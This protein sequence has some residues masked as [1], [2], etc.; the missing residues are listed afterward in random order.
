MQEGQE[1]QESGR[2][3]FVYE[4]ERRELPAELLREIE[5]QKLQWLN[6]AD[7][8]QHTLERE[9]R[10]IAHGSLLFLKKVLRKAEEESFSLAILPTPRQPKLARLLSL[11]SVE[12][13]LVAFLGSVEPLPLD[14]LYA[15]EEPVFFSALVGEAPPLG[16][17]N[18]VLNEDLECGG[19]LRLFFRALWRV[20]GLRRVLAEVTTAKG[21]TLKTAITGALIFNREAN[22]FAANLLQES[23][24]NDGQLR[25]LLI[26]PLSVLSYLHHLI[27][28]IYAR[29][30]ESSLPGSVG[31][32]KSES[33]TIR[34]DPPLQ[35]SV[36]GVE[37]GETPMTFRVHPKAIR[38]CA[39]ERFWERNRPTQSEK[40][41]L[42][43][44][45]LPK[46]QEAKEVIRK[47]LPLL[48]HASEE[49]YKELFTT[50][51]ADGRLSST[52]VILMI[53]STL[54]ATVG[55]FLN[56]AS[57]VIGAMLLAPLMQPIVTFA[58][59]LL[60]W[61]GSLAYGALRTVSVGVA[62]V[63]LSSLIL[64]A[65]LPFRELTSEMAGRLHPTLL[66]LLV[67]VVSGIAAAYAKNNPKISGSL[68]GVAIAVALVPPLS[69]A[70]IGLGW[71][72]FSIF[73][74]AFL[75]FLT[76]FAGIILAAALV[77]MLMGFSPL[78]RAKKGLV[79]GLL[80]VVL[81]ALPLTL[82]F[83]QM[84]GDAKLRQQLQ[85][86]EFLIDSKRVRIDSIRILH[87][88]EDRLY[89]D[90]VVSS[91]LDGR[92]LETLKRRI[93][94]L[95]GQTLPLEIMQRIHL[96]A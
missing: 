77:F 27:V 68:V 5:E 67:A 60:R 75:L 71:G 18:R 59:G 47:H 16:L 69:T 2:L 78:H 41:T 91:P 24:Y 4:G 80:M 84:V 36:D 35:I 32:I 29:F 7:F 96:G 76:N 82:S 58:M 31:L 62:L 53:L 73:I 21:Q 1:K 64:A 43:V 57:V 46:E 81:V 34:C 95:T 9:D 66:D 23:S 79:F 72:E 8:F 93:D 56:S 3:Y 26:S 74:Q 13:S 50:L 61:D 11:S 70:G 83:R 30:R 85:R 39:P 49:E 63:L 6:A 14:L 22:S 92:E 87:G 19:R 51:R 38:F 89:I 12:G 20:R 86:R 15:E 28:S 65:L 33:L 17:Q 54:L 25:A 94:S 52:F 45:H 42:R 90:L 48:N 40:E 44:D 10:T 37:Q 55:L 88:R